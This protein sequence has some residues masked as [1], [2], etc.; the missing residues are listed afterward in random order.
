MSSLPRV[1]DKPREQVAREF[2]ARGLDACMAEIIW[3]L[4]RAQS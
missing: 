1:T 4:E 3:H 2:H